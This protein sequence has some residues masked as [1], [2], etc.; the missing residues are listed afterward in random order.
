[1]KKYNWAILGL[2]KIAHKFAQDLLLT[3]HGNLYAVASRS[4]DKATDFAN[5]YKAEK[6]Y[7]SYEEMMFDKKI[8]VV[9]IATPHIF[10]CQ[11]TLMCLD[12]G[13]HVLCEKAFGMN[14]GEV[15]MMIDKAKEKD[16]FLMEALWTRF[17]PATEKVLEMIAD[18]AIGEVRL[19]KADFGF[20]A[21]YDPSSR[22]FD[23]KLGGGALLDIGIYPVFLSL[24]ALG[25][26]NN[27]RAFAQMSPTEV[28][29]NVAMFF[30]YA[31]GQ[32]AILDA[33]LEEATAIEGWLHGTKATIKMNNRFHHT[34]KLNILTA[35][36][37]TDTT[38]D[39]PY[40]GN[41][42]YHEI[43][44][45]MECLDNG[46]TESKK[47]PLSFSLDLI[48]TLDNVRKAILIKN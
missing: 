42:Y 3:E 18:D 34:T 38:I 43:L 44:E 37:N 28:D 25:K 48:Q 40:V 31:N 6:A 29:S 39:I 15:Q 36:S 8:D 22:L 10:H 11:N 24:L 12:A 16:L 21:H 35:G 47:L 41:G 46:Q 2:G 7:G 27:I 26:P 30:E 19:V 14:E 4:M 13:F 32:R 1:M 45:V 17:I 33:T 5:Q 20:R 9:Y 23:K